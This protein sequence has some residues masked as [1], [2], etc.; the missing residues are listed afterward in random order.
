MA[1]GWAVL[2][3]L[4]PTELTRLSNAQIQ[5]HLEAETRA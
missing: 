2:R 5:K 3:G 4:P 1:A